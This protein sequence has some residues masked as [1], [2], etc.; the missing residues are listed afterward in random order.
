MSSQALKGFFFLEGK[1]KMS[2][3]DYM[4]DNNRHVYTIENGKIIETVISRESGK[5]LLRV[6]LK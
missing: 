4:S 3:T 6:V 1:K 5:I 2:Y